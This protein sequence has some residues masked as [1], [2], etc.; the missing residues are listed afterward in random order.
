MDQGDDNIP[1]AMAPAWLKKSSCI[2]INSYMLHNPKFSYT[3][4]SAVT[5]AD[6]KIVVFAYTYRSM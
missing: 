5:Q 6:P 2:P 3:F 4:V 1:R